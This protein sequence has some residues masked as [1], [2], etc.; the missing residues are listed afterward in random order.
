MSSPT[1]LD[2]VDKALPEAFSGPSWDGWRVALAGVFGLPL[3]ADQMPA[4]QTLSGRTTAPQAPVRE[5]WLVCGR[6]AGKSRV[7]AV[8]AVYLATCRTFALAPGEKA[9][10]MVIATDTRQA[11]VVHRYIAGLLRSTPVLAQLIARATRSAIELTNG[12]IIEIHTASF[13]SVRGYTVVAAILDEIAYWPTDDASDPDTEIL[14]AIRP[15]MATVP[16]AL[17]V[18][19]SSPY[20]RAGELWRAYRQH[21]GQDA[22]DV[23]VIQAPT[24]VLNPTVPQSVIDRALLEDA[25]RARAEYL[26][27]FRSDVDSYISAAVVQACVDVGV[28]ERPPRPPWRYHAFADPAGGSGADS[29]TLAIGHTEPDGADP[30]VVIDAVRAV[31]PPFNPSSVV[32]EFAALLKTYRVASVTG[33]RYAGFWP[34]EAFARHGIR[35]DASAAPRSDLYRDALPL[36][37]AQRLALLD[38]PV[39]LHQITRLERRTGWGGRDSIDHAPGAHD[40]LANAVLG[41]AATCQRQ[42]AGGAIRGLTW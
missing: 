24:R 19:L 26:A 41:F 40:D 23:L 21:Y 2:F 8:C 22:S 28:T 17:L 39:L 6:R 3:T 32:G 10:V 25:P 12:L 11:R 38:L 15:A 31:S 14:A 29:F 27:E 36:L 35:Y 13:R 20:R 18:G 5:A 1:L 9:V 16:G 34:S 33:D 42:S 7:A 30:V 37:N 4:W